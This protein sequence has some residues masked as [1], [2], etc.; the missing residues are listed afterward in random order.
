MRVNIPTVQQHA[1]KSDAILTMAALR[2][3]KDHFEA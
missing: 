3:E 1:G 2:E